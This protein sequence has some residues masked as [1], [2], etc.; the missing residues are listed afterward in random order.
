MYDRVLDDPRLSRWYARGDALPHPALD[1]DRRAL[2]AQLG[3]PL[4]TDR[5]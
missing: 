4:A 5:R 3:V 2:E 1:V